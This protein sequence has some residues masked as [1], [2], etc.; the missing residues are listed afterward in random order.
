MLAALELPRTGWLALVVLGFTSAAVIAVL[1]AED[2]RRWWRH[3]N[4]GGDTD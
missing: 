3:R 2:V 4:G 1:L